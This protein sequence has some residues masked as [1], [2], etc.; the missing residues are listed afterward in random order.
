MAENPFSFSFITSSSWLF[1]YFSSFISNCTHH[2][3]HT[4]VCLQNR[5]VRW[6]PFFDLKF[7][8]NSLRF[9]FTP[10]STEIPP[11]YSNFET[12]LPTPVL[13]NWLGNHFGTEIPPNSNVQ[14]HGPKVFKTLLTSKIR[15]RRLSLLPVPDVPAQTRHFTNPNGDDDAIARLMFV[16]THA[17]FFV[18]VFSLCNR[19]IQTHTHIAVVFFFPLLAC[20]VFALFLSSVTID[21]LIDWL[22]GCH[23]CVCLFQTHFFHPVFPTKF[24]YQHTHG[25]ATCPESL[26]RGWRKSANH[27]VKT[28]RL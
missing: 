3:V 19:K 22:T 20:A 1:L 26:S 15:P 25:T 4:H 17:L 23:S 27:G 11:I 21:W 7:K 28:I 5:C 14:S 16:S 10:W 24:A 12:F 2:N 8:I 9:L 18:R 6:F 13:T